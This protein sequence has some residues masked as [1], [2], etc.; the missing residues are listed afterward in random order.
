ML[1]CSKNVVFG[2]GH[3]N[4]TCDFPD[5]K[6]NCYT[7]LFISV[8]LQQMCPLNTDTRQKAQQR[9]YLYERHFQNYK[10]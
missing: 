3:W 2:E 6:I 7:D 4:C 9:H 8:Y 1:L 5:C 10:I